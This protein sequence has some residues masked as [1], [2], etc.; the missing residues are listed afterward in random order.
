MRGKTRLALHAA[1]DAIGSH[2][3][4]TWWVDLAAVRAGAD[5]AEALGRAV[6][7]APVTGVDSL[8]AVARRLSGAD[9]TLVVLDNAEHV[10]DDAARVAAALLVAS[11]QVHVLVT[12]REPL[13]VPGEVIWRVPS[14]SSPPAGAAI[15]YEEL[16]GYEAVRL[17]LERARQG[18]PDLVLDESSARPIAHICRRLDGIPLAIELAAARARTLPLDHLAGGLDDAFRL[19]TGGSRTVLAR[20]QTL[21]ASIAWSVDLL[22]AV[23]GAVF[24]RL[25][26]FQGSFTLGSAEAVAADDARVDRNAVLDVLGRLVDKS[27]VQLDP[28]TGRYRLLETVRQFGLDRLREA[29]ELADVRS[30]HARRY[31]TWAREVA[32]GRHGIDFAA[33]G[34]DAPDATAALRWACDESPYDAYRILGGLARFLDVLG[35]AARRDAVDWFVARDGDDDPAGWASAAAAVALQALNMDRLDL[36]ELVPRALERAA[37]D[38]GPTVRNLQGAATIP[39]IMLGRLE[40]SQI[41]L[42]EALVAGDDASALAAASATAVLAVRTGRLP[43]AHELLTIIRRILER[44]GLPFDTNTARIGVQVAIELAHLE[45][46]LADGLLIASAVRSPEGDSRLSTASSVAYLA[47]IA[48]DDELLARAQAWGD[49]DPPPRACVPWSPT[50]GSSPRWPAAKTLSPPS[51]PARPGMGYCRTVPSS[52]CSRRSPCRRSSATAGLTRRRHG[53]PSGPSRSTL[54]APSP[55]T[56]RS[57]TNGAPS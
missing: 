46:R 22:D 34:V 42:R 4:G 49:E 11:P 1:A 43:L 25:A 17:F 8:A 40:P 18:R 15:P 6:G 50:S 39:S 20:Q 3:G 53:S 45:A 28:T 2:P 5:V 48:G 37:P 32:E 41:A 54:L 27:L 47:Y 23:E 19:L 57:A 30:R 55:P 52:V 21:L 36:V 12:S 51:S 24:R 35:P 29:G 9:S 16:G 31:S 44:S 33:I 56:R 38:D 14:L 26:V 7:M 13:G 10:V